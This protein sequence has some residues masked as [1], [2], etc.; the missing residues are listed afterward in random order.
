[1]RGRRRASL[2]RRS[3]SANWL[4]ARTWSPARAASTPARAAVSPVASKVRLRSTETAAAKVATSASAPTIATATKTTRRTR[5]GRWRTPDVT[6]SI[7]M[8]TPTA[9]EPRAGAVQGR[10]NTD[11]AITAP[12]SA[13]ARSA[14][15]AAARSTAA[16]ARNATSPAA[17]SAHESPAATT[18]AAATA[19]AIADALVAA[20][21]IAAAAIPQRR[22]SVSALPTGAQLASAPMTPLVATTAS[23]PTR[24]N[25]RCSVCASTASGPR[26]SELRAVVRVTGLY[27]SGKSRVIRRVACFTLLRRPPRAMSA[28]LGPIKCSRELRRRV[29]ITAM[30]RQ[31]LLRR[32]LAVRFQSFCDIA[33]SNS[34]RFVRLVWERPPR[35]GVL[36][37]I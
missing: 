3:A 5:A 17:C 21:V 7:A 32:T 27:A 1:M 29:A 31:S 36:I 15:V 18:V 25:E 28:A 30:C 33:S 37:K 6:I 12:T 13:R 20:S 26:G 11:C 34:A 22:W 35:M 9:A 4:A 23:T 24:S 14:C 16:V 2:K 8:A 10:R 19:T